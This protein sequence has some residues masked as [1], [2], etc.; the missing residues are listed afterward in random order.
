M[1][2]C[3]LVVDDEPVNV[4]LARHTLEG[5]GYEV[6]TAQDGLE[7]LEELKKRIPD[8]ILLDVQM[9]RMN[10]Y[11]FILEKLKNCTNC[12]RHFFVATLTTAIVVH[13]SS[14]SISCF[15]IHRTKMTELNKVAT[16]TKEAIFIMLLISKEEE[17]GC[18]QTMHGL[19]I[20]YV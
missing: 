3:I 19:D 18:G 14:T 15:S 17:I 1:P 11:T 16:T 20:K 2:K 8:L 12:N 7:A 6:I 4:G 13:L 5:N 9:P 10:G